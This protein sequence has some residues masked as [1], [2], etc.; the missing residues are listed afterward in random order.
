MVRPPPPRTLRDPSEGSNLQAIWGATR[1]F[2]ALT[3]AAC[4]MSSQACHTSDRGVILP[5]K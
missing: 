4:K 3:T 5:S 1:V 2:R